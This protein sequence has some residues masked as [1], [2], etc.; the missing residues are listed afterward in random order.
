MPG[1][2]PEPTGPEVVVVYSFSGKDPYDLLQGKKAE[3]FGRDKSERIEVPTDL[4]EYRDLVRALKKA[5]YRARLYNI[6]DSLK[7]LERLLRQG[8]DR[9]I[10][11]L[12]E[13]FEEDSRL[14]AAVAGMYELYSVPYT[15][16]GV[17]ALT[18]C[19]RKALTKQLL[20][21]EG[22]PTPRY[23]L[24][25]K[26]EIERRH[27][28]RFPLIVKPAREDASAG[29]DE[30]SVVKN[31]AKLMEQINRSFDTFSP[32]I[33][34]EEFI[35]GRELHVSILGNNPPEVLPILEYDFSKA[36]KDYPKIVSSDVKWNPLSDIFHKVDE[37]CPAKLTPA[38]QK[39]INEIALRAYEITECRDYARLDVRLA[40]SGR[41]TILEVNPNPD[42]SEGIS[43]M[44]SAEKADY[45]YHEALGVI[46]E[47]AIVRGKADYEERQ[48]RKTE[49][50]LP[51]SEKALPPG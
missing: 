16:A 36:P 48:R 50:A 30:H 5:G 28:L 15:G 10:F 41:P 44:Y 2:P 31:H 45:D 11:N 17:F 18:I 46:V 32:P 27:G 14:E 43:F 34:V 12:V 40:P 29:V 37:V 35:E 26:P 1:K 19:Q 6:K 3:D 51:W 24:L 9:V 47:C 4:E 33:L 7:R 49:I 8:R 38:A 25:W 20:I 39:K 21:A 22:V 42:L 13:S 23:R